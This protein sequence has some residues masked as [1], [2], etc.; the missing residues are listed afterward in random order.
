MG[1]Q[2][3]ATYNFI[4]MPL[5]ASGNRF[6]NGFKFNAS[7]HLATIPHVAQLDF[8]LLDDFSISTFIIPVIPGALTI[9]RLINKYG[10]S[11]G[12]NF[13][14][15]QT[16]TVSYTLRFYFQES[17][18]VF[19]VKQFVISRD[20][21]G[22]WCHF[23]MTKVSGV[24]PNNILIYINGQLVNA[25]V[26][27][28][29][30][31]NSVGSKNGYDLRIN[32]GSADAG[33]FA[34]MYQGPLSI[35]NKVLSEVEVFDLYKRDGIPTKALRS[36]LLMSYNMSEKSGTTITDESSNANNATLS[37]TG[38]VTSLGVTNQ[39]VDK[40]QQPITS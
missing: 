29:N 7:N 11:Q 32:G 28:N 27:S 34:V 16:S 6:L 18:T 24:S 10:A 2:F 21:R 31:T 4:I 1:G 40:Y 23:A 36:N 13:D 14:L 17:S 9:Y 25:T 39:W 20:I 3:T 33:V 30:L 12:W 35:Y 8:G 38:M 19:G 26:S 22:Q 5:I 15:I 37:G